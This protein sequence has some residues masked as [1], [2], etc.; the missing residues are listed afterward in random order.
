MAVCVRLQILYFVVK[1]NEWQFGC[2]LR[3]FNLLAKSKWSFWN[4]Y[5]NFVFCSQRTN[6]AILLYFIVKN[7]WPFEYNCRILYFGVKKRMTAWVHAFSK[8]FDLIR[9]IISIINV[10]QRK[11]V[12][13]NIYFY[14]QNLFRVVAFFIYSFYLNYFHFSVTK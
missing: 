14:W 1:K 13:I 9:F 12:V 7:E 2:N 5:K 10:Y 3:F 4:N 11:T 8:S 6:I